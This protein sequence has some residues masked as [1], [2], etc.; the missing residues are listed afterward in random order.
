M[1]QAIGTTWLMQLIIIFM[2]IFVAFLALTINFT[3][4]FKIKNELINIIEKNEGLTEGNYGT[5]YFINNYLLNNGY[6]TKGSCEADEY[7]KNTLSLDDTSMPTGAVKGEKYYYCIKKTSY[8]TTV[9]PNRAKYT[10]RIFFH[11]SLPVIG[12]I[13]TFSSEGT[14]IDLNYAVDDIE[15]TG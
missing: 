3:K 9:Y 6:M 14:T 11:F 13:F 1:R 12:D 5:I 8:Y 2:L 15:A 4:A 10:I 7:G